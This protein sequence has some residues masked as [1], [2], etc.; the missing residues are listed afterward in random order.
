MKLIFNSF[1]FKFS[2]S[3]WLMQLFIHFVNF[4]VYIILYS[5]FSLSVFNMNNCRLFTPFHLRFN[6]IVMQHPLTY[7][8]TYGIENHKNRCSCRHWICLIPYVDHE[9][10]TLP[11]NLIQL[12][13]FCE[14]VSFSNFFK[15]FFLFISVALCIRIV[16]VCTIQSN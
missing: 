12:R 6:N 8:V 16:Y 4:E 13:L 5:C 9:M 1:I 15:L 7:I 10:L 11:D 14:I 2:C 3:R